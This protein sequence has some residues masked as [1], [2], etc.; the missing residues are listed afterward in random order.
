MIN[1]NTVFF[2][3]NLKFLEFIVFLKKHKNIIPFINGTFCILLVP[4]YF[5]ESFKEFFSLFL[6]RLYYQ[7]IM[8]KVVEPEF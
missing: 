5:L 8:F 4:I 3:H 2:Y 6:L 1:L 7:R